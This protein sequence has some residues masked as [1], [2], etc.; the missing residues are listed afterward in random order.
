M[1]EKLNAPRGDDPVARRCVKE[2]GR[3]DRTRDPR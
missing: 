3:R 2:Q 1:R